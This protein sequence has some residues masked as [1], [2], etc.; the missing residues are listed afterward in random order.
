MTTQQA[1]TINKKSTLPMKEKFEDIRREIRS[2]HSK[3]DNAK[4]KE[5]R[6]KSAN[7][8]LQNNT[9]KTKYRA[10]CTPLKPWL[11]SDT[12]EGIVIAALHVTPI[13]LL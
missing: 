1:V 11:N 6:S 8:D 7:N 5:K 9:Q 13:V 12:Q 10:P 4:E 3:K 2:L